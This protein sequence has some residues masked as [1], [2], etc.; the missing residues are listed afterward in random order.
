MRII[1]FWLTLC[2]YSS[3]RDPWDV[4]LRCILNAGIINSFSWS[5]IEDALEV[6]GNYQECYCGKLLFVASLICLQNHYVTLF[7]D[8]V[9]LTHLTANRK[10]WF[11]C[12]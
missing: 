6:M 1:C 4:D 10:L 2:Q 3:E 5:Q 7:S 8:L 12:I 11:S 9:F